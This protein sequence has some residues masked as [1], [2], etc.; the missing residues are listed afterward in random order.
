MIRFIKQIVIAA[1]MVA[2][3]NGHNYAVGSNNYDNEDAIQDNSN[4]AIFKNGV[5]RYTD[6]VT[7]EVKDVPFSALTNPYKGTFSLTKF[8]DRSEY[9]VITTDVQ[10]FFKVGGRNEKK[11]VVLVSLRQV[12]EEQLGKSAAPFAPVMAGWDIAKAR[13]GIFWRS[14]N[15]VN[16]SEY[17]YLTSAS[18]ASISSEN[19]H[20]NWA[21]AEDLQHSN[22]ISL[23]SISGVACQKVFHVCFFEPE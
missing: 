19:L 15:N 1:L 20:K 17:D 3:C 23:K 13:M 7:Q 6:P 18:L 22:L 5:L 10:R 16:L 2:F 14:G 8:G 4:K 11:A 21:R 9:L 12:I